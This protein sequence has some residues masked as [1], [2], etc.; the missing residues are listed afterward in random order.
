MVSNKPLEINIDIEEIISEKV[1]GQI[2]EIINEADNTI[3]QVEIERV[4]LDHD[5]DTYA[6]TLALFA[7]GYVVGDKTTQVVS[8]TIYLD[9]DNN[10]WFM[11]YLE[12]AQIYRVVGN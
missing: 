1:K 2:V 11:D 10:Q 6:N 5:E 3:L 7:V 4:E 8:K 9:V 12:V